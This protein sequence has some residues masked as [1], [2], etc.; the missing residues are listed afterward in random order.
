M[1][2]RTTDWF[3]NDFFNRLR[4]SA[5]FAITEFYEVRIAPARYPSAL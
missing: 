1:R 2:F 3:Y 5:N 4:N